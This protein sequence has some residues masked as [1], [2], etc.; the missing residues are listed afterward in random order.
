M[1]EFVVRYGILTVE[2]AKYLLGLFACLLVCLLG[3]R[4]GLTKV[5]V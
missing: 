1:S 2:V 4:M 3:V 5:Q